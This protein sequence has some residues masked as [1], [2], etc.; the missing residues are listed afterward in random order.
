MKIASVQISTALITAKPTRVEPQL[1][2]SEAGSA[3]AGSARLAAPGQVKRSEQAG[4][5]AERNAWQAS[6][7]SVSTEQWLAARTSWMAARDTPQGGTQPPQPVETL[8]S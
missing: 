8:S 7:K 5:K 1:P 2:E 3:P 4:W 6:H